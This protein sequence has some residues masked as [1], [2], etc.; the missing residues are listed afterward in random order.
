MKHC[1]FINNMFDNNK[2]KLQ[3]TLAGNF[4]ENDD[5]VLPDTLWGEL[6]YIF[7]VLKDI[8]SDKTN[9][10][11]KSQNLIKQIKIHVRWMKV[12]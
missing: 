6:I 1:Y 10:E 2:H 9:R 7:Y 4:D 5:V 8:I 3:K 12:R 11:A